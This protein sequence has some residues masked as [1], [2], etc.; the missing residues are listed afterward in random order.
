MPR[1]CD[2]TTSVRNAA[3][4][5]Q[6]NRC[7]HCGESLASHEDHAHHVVPNQSGDPGNEAHA[8]VRTVDNCVVCTTCHYAV[9]ECGRYTTGAVAP[10]SYYPHSYGPDAPPHRLWVSQFD[11]RGSRVYMASPSASRLA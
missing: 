7:A 6:W 1:P 11:A 2:F 4:S 10:L 9:H 3:F 5:R 8:F